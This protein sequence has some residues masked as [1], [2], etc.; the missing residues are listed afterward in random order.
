LDD[1]LFN[2]YLRY[3]NVE[4]SRSDAA[5][6]ILF[7]IRPDRDLNKSKDF[8]W[9]NDKLTALR[10]NYPYAAIIIAQCDSRTV[11][12]PDNTLDKLKLLKQCIA[13]KKGIKDHIQNIL[14]FELKLETA[15]HYHPN[16]LGDINDS[17]EEEKLEKTDEQKDAL[18]ARDIKKIAELIPVMKKRQLLHVCEDLNS[19]KNT[20]DKLQGKHW[21]RVRKKREH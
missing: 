4:S 21:E 13:P 9:V 15:Y 10:K 19:L 5:C 11:N 7:T 12:T 20:L 18:F 2:G 14:E 16:D 6:I 1:S 8:N 17:T 3:E